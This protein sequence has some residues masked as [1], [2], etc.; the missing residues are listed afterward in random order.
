MLWP[1]YPI[2]ARTSFFYLFVRSLLFAM[3]LTL[4]VT[5]C[6]SPSTF[7]VVTATLTMI[8]RTWVAN[9]SI[10]QGV[11]AWRMPAASSINWHGLLEEDPFRKLCRASELP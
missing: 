7:F 4:L 8:N 5:G 1:W 2:V 9:L 3:M 10:L 6:V 11:R